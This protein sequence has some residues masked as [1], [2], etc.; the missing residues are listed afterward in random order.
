MSADATAPEATLSPT[1]QFLE[2][3]LRKII[4]LAI[5]IVIGLGASWLVSHNARVAAEAAAEEVTAAKTVDDCDLV[6]RKHAGSIAAAN[7]LLLKATLQ[8]DKNE[9]SDSVKTLQ[10]FTSQFPKHPFYGQTLLAIA[11]KKELLGEKTEAKVGYEQV[12]ASFPNTELAQLAQIRLGDLLW[13]EG[14]EAEAKKA[15]EEATKSFPGLTA[16]EKESSERLTW[17]ASSLPTK[18]VE[19][20]PAPKPPAPPPG[21]AGLNLKGAEG[22]IKATINPSDLGK[23]PLMLQGAPTPAP[24]PAPPPTAT[25]PAVEV[26]VTPA[27]KPATPS[28]P[29]PTPPVPAP[30]VP[31]TPPTPAPTVPATPPAPAPSIPA[32]PPVPAPAPAPAK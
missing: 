22:G 1:E 21:A 28:T 11:S 20:P 4:W 15:Y 10:E 5:L 14:K 24:A 18:E 9:K 23:T 25:S 6:I 32:A 12:L 3:N 17:L 27:P 16:F 29:A 8:W 30:T 19:A 26:P 7:A 2:K 13:A 31:A